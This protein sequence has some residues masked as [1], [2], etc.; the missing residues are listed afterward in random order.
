MSRIEETILNNLLYDEEYARKVIPFLKKEYF[1]DAVE[2]IL[3]EEI[4]KFFETYTELATKE[5]LGIE[6][7]NRK[8]VNDTQ[9]QEAQNMLMVFEKTPINKEW[10]LTETEAFCKQR[11][12]YL[13]ILDS[14]Q[15]IEGT[16]KKYTQEAIPALLT[17]ALSVCF[18]TSVG[19]DYFEDADARFEYYRRKEDK[20]PFD[21]EILNKITGGGLSKKSLTVYL[22][23]CVH[24]ET[25]VRVRMRLVI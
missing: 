3:S 19:H 5:I 11:A 15:I 22:A 20:I 2:G 8:D 6:I 4:F 25:K 18:D 24:P 12:V 9:L 21:I 17:E 23:G 16:D 14:I 1:S 10:L 13:A 7:S